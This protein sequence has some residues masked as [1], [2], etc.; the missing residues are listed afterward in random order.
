VKTIGVKDKSLSN[1]RDQIISYDEALRFCSSQ[2]APYADKIQIWDSR[3]IGAGSRC[4]VPSLSLSLL[5]IHLTMV[6]M[7]DVE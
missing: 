6:M 1:T 4:L 7:Y 3:N 2:S 5:K